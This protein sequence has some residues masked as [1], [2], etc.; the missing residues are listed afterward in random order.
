MPP[1]PNPRLHKELYL[2]TR[3]ARAST[4][5]STAGRWDSGCVYRRLLAGFI[6]LVLLLLCLLVPSLCSFQRSLVLTSLSLG[7]DPSSVFP[8]FCV[9]QASPDPSYT[10]PC[11]AHLSVNT[12]PALAEATPKSER[13]FKR[14]L[15]TSAQEGQHRE[16]S[17]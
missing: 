10:Q 1:L 7:K 11:P 2:Y 17:Q 4:E 16:K 15:P 3:A 14:V 6:N 12:A 5:G 8:L 9:S 13:N